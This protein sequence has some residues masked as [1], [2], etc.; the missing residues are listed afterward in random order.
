MKTDIYICP[1][2]KKELDIK[3]GIKPGLKNITCRNHNDVLV[4]CIYKYDRINHKYIDTELNYIWLI[5]KNYPGCEILILPDKSIH[6]CQNYKII[7]ELP[8]DKDLIPENLEEKLGN[9]IKTYLLF[10]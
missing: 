7:V 5:H 3:P 6:I 8:F 10:Q 4:E 1:Y 2:C 9:K